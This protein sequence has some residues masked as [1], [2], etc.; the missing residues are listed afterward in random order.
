MSTIEEEFEDYLA[1]FGVPGMK[2]GQRK[3]ELNADNP[4]YTNDQ[5]KRD[6]QV[7]GRG[8]AKRINK[9]LNR[10]DSISTARGSEK[11]RRDKVL[12]RNKYVRQGG[13]VAGTLGGVVVANVG[14]SALSKVAKSSG[15]QKF[16]SKIFG[17]GAGPAISSIAAFANTPAV[18]VAASSG[19]AYV[20]NMMAGDIAVGIN[21]RAGGYDPNRKY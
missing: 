13:K 7:Y 18:R 3:R 20:G 12:G 17:S 2:W 10:G 15:G 21:T 1:H 11:L 5:R 8:G 16:V 9:N 4:N 6:K 14:I 19:A